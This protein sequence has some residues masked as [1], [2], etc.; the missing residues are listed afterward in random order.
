MEFRP[1]ETDWPPDSTDPDAFA[2]GPPLRVEPTLKREAL[3]LPHPATPAPVDDR[4]TQHPETP[5]PD[6][7]TERGRSARPGG[8]PR[9]RPGEGA[10]VR[11]EFKVSPAERDQL[12]ELARHA[13]ISVSEYLRRRAFG[14]PVV[15]LVE[16]VERRE[17]RRELGRLGTNLNQLVR[18]ANEAAPL[19]P[20]DRAA[21][22]E[23]VIGEVRDTLAALR[24]ASE[25]LRLAGQSGAESDGDRSH[26]RSEDAE[27]RSGTEP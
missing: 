17:A 13:G 18:R 9:R 15:P 12:R 7:P 20:P 26:V 10:P 27:R 14:L 24:A 11:V 22:V 4:P 23:G 21:A 25:S 19:L 6:A 3:G 5:E 16:A 1:D 8:R 2:A